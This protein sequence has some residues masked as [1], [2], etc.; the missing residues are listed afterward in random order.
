[1]RKPRVLLADGHK[2]VAEGLSRLL[3][4]D[5]NVVGI[6]EDGQAM[7]DA[8]KRVA[9]DVIVADV[10]MPRLNGIEAV[11]KLRKAG[12][13]A[14]VILLSMHRDAGYA[15]RSIEAGA[16]GFVLKHSTSSD[17][18]TAIREALEGRTYVTP[19]LV[20]DFLRDS[21]EATGD[22]SGSPGRL[23]G[24]QQ[25]VLRLLVEGHSV[26][27]IAHKLHLSPRTIEFHKY[28]VMRALKV[29]TVVD[30]VRYAIRHGIVSDD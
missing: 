9:P 2:L 8:A 30:L 26:K 21:T 14:V 23:T 1:L 25:E 16:A 29:D 28:S 19:S 24:R 12:S 20:A 11:K 13:T 18:I 6:V 4:P 22:P 27:E 10:T 3:E 7:V 5:F 17:L 15:R